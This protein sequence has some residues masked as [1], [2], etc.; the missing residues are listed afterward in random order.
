[1]ITVFLTNFQSLYVDNCT[2]GSN[3]LNKQNMVDEIIVMGPCEYN[4][5]KE[6]AERHVMFL[7]YDCMYKAL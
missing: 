6:I 7:R 4:N 3:K 1:M 5:T 2:T